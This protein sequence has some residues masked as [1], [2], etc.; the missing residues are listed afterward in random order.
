[1]GITRIALHPSRT[2]RNVATTVL[3]LAT[4]FAHRNF[5]HDL[6]R[7]SVRVYRSDGASHGSEE[8]ERDS[9]QE[10]EAL[11]TCGT[12]S[13]KEPNL[14]LSIHAVIPDASAL[15]DSSPKTT[16]PFLA[17]YVPLATPISR[18]A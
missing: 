9:L 11:T 18:T 6:G 5:D 7:G 2:A 3:V 1:M 10:K 14:C 13:K 4:V 17:I 16:S 15:R 8:S 12:T